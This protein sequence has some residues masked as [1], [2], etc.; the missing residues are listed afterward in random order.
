MTTI[1]STKPAARAP[2]FA[3]QAG[4][5]AA[6]QVPEAGL[7]E[8]IIGDLSEASWLVAM[9]RLGLGLSPELLALHELEA[10]PGSARNSAPAAASAASG[11]QPYGATRAPDFN[12]TRR[13]QA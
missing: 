4:T 9:S 7:I 5:R 11:I 1:V 2:R 8:W 13:V 3:P 10:E 12:Q 6:A